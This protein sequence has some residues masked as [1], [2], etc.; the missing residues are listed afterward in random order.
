MAKKV[1]EELE[2]LN[3]FDKGVNYDMFL[4]S[5]PDGVSI[6]KHLEGKITEEQMAFLLNDLSIYKQSKNK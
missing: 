4:A 2:F 1:N 6:E 5:V 3:P